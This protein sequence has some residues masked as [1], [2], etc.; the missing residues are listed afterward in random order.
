MGI[1]FLALGYERGLLHREVFAGFG[2]SSDL[3]PKGQTMSCNFSSAA[4]L[5]W[6][7]FILENIQRGWDPCPQPILSSILGMSCGSHCL[8]GFPFP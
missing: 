2:G 3:K 4:G 1:Y 6:F 5:R 7:L 8:S